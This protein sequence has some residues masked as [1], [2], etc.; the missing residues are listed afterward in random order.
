M[1]KKVLVIDDNPVDRYVA[2]RIFKKYSFAEEIVCIDSARKGLEYLFSFKDTPEQL[3]HFIFLDIMMPEMNG[4]EFLEEYE[5][6][7]DTIKDSCTVLMLTTSIHTDDRNK[8]K[9][10]PYV[11]KFLN[12][13]LSLAILK[14]LEGL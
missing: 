12:K 4:F 9:D 8:A 2:E 1:H 10:N 5:S 11:S 7:P 14:E 3:P 13:P 6:L